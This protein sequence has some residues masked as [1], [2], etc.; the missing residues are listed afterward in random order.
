LSGKFYGLS[1]K[2]IRAQIFCLSGVETGHFC[3]E[4]RVVMLNDLT[5]I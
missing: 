1:L 2:N 5:Q 3:S 4:R